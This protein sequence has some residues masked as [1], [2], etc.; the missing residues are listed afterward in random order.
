MP[1][2]VVYCEKCRRN[3]YHGN[4]GNLSNRITHRLAHCLNPEDNYPNGYFIL[5]DDKT[6][7]HGYNRKLLSQMFI[8]PQNGRREKVQSTLL[9]VSRNYLGECK[10]IRKEKDNGATG[11]EAK[12]NSTG[13]Y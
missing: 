5:I 13:L 7:R 6:K 1:Q 9:E 2:I 12:T 11:R 4:E 10:G 3:H 8:K